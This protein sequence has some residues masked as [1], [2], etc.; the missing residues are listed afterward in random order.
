MQNLKLPKNEQPA[1]AYYNERQ[2]HLFELAKQT[3]SDHYVLYK[4]IN[5]NHYQKLGKS[6]NPLELEEK[7]KVIETM[8]R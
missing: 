5:N 3:G 2:Q 8:R 1:V 4:V 7:F 6:K